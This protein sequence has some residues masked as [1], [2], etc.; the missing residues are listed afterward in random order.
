MSNLDV[1]SKVPIFVVA[2]VLVIVV[3]ITIYI[4]IRYWRERKK[5]LLEIQEA[6]MTLNRD[7]NVDGIIPN[8]S[9]YPQIDLLP[10]DN[11]FEFPPKKLTL[12]SQKLGEGSYG[13]VFEATAKGIIPNEENTTVAVKMLKMNNFD[14]EEVHCIQKTFS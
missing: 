6:D 4:S 1:P 2:T 9:L 12:K 7:G 13:V 14:R 10:Y 11:A 5:L 8:S 3:S